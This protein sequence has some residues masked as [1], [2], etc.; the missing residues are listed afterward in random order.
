MANFFL[1]MSI[2]NTVRVNQR[3]P[4]AKLPPENV[5]TS[6]C[7]FER[8]HIPTVSSDQTQSNRSLIRRGSQIV[9]QFFE[10]GKMDEAIQILSIV[11]DKT[12]YPCRR[13]NLY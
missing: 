3:H 9:R 5:W 4:L 13:H 12:F 2:H 11:N 8:D 6:K 1:S 7:F 10:Q